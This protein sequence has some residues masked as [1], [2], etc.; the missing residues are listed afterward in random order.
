[1]GKI[2]DAGAMMETMTPPPALCAV[3]TSALCA[4]PAEGWMK[5]GGGV[6]Q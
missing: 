1:M 5:A 3:G 2:L 4:D 6:V